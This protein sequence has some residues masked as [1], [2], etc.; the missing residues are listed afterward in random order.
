MRVLIIASCRCRGVKSG[1]QQFARDVAAW[2]F[3]ESLVLRLDQVEHHLVNETLP[4]ETYTTNDQV[5]RYMSHFER[6]YPG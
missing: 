1:N 4:R 6:I 5:V 3:K 2:T